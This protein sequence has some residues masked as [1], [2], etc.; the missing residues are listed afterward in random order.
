MNVTVEYTSQIKR[1]AGHSQESYALEENATVQD[2][3]KRIADR[4]HEKL[5][6]VLYDENGSILPTVLIFVDDKQVANHSGQVLKDDETVTF[7]SPI[8]GG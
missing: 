6:A 5:Q 8:S 2:L 3:L 4:H 7:L 1:A